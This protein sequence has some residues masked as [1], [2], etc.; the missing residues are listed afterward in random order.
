MGIDRENRLQQGQRG[1]SVEARQLHLNLA[2]G[3]IEPVGANPVHPAMG[4][5]KQHPGQSAVGQ[6]GREH[7]QAV[8]IGP[9]QIIDED[10]QRTGTGDDSEQLAQPIE[11][12]AA[13]LVRIRR[14]LDRAR[15]DRFGDLLQ[16]WKQ[17]AQE[18]G[19]AWHKGGAFLG[20]KLADLASELVDHTIEG[21][22]GQKLTLVAARGND[23]ACL[24]CAELFEKLVA[25]FALPDAGLTR[26]QNRDSCSR[27][28]VREGRLQGRHGARP[29]K[30]RG[31]PDPALTQPPRRCRRRAHGL[32]GRARVRSFVGRPGQQGFAQVNQLRCDVRDKLARRRGILVLLPVQDLV[33]LAIEGQNPG[34]RLVQHH[35]K[36]VPICCGTDR[37]VRR[38]FRR[39]VR[40]GA[41]PEKR[42]PDFPFGGKTKVENHNPALARDQHVG[43][44]DVSVNLSCAVDGGQ[45]LGELREPLA[46]AGLVQGFFPHGPVWQDC[47]LGASPR[48]SVRV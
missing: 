29:A 7:G 3:R 43:R 38:L 46:H 19:D 39:H 16:G 32:Q 13:Q 24:I 10:H 48:F 12:T 11:Q 27:D 40:R 1:L 30:Q 21:F 25:E 26:D 20:G 41:R 6:Q 37:I 28:H 2:D 8:G 22:E 15:H 31:G 23:R 17:V 5:Q 47:V 18:R 4:S 33:R 44:L 36:A 45:T 42:R 35:A 14:D 9:L 34:Q